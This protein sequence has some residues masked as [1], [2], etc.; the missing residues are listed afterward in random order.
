MPTIGELGR[1]SYTE[2]IDA[3]VDA[4]VHGSRY[5]LELAT[6]EMRT[7][8]ANAPFGPPRTAFYQYLA[9]LDPDSPVVTNWAKRLGHSRVALIPTLSIYYLDLPNHGNPWKEEIA[10]I[11][12]PKDVHLPADRETGQAQKGPGIP[13]GLSESVLRIEER[14]RRAGARYLAGSGTSAF[15]TLPGISL[16]NELRMLTDLGLTPRQALAAATS[17]V[18]EIFRWTTVGRIAKGYDADVVV[19]DADPTVDIRNLQKI[20][21]VILKGEIVDRPALLKH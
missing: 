1:T 4:F 8:V 7:A 13:A 14:N 10:A 2:A 15:G 20:R 12:D 16:H 5:A 9:A 21:M 17:N 3:G 6:P 11:L 19:V 18:G